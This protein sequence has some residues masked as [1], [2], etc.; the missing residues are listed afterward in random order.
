MEIDYTKLKTPIEFFYQWEKRTPNAVFLRQPSGPDWKTLTY[1]EAGQEARKMAAALQATGLEQGSHVGI[2]SKNC[3]HWVLSDLAIMMAGFVSVPFYPSLT[4]GQLHEV[5]TKSNTRLLIAGKLEEWE[6]K[7]AGVPTGLPII[8]F[9]HYAGN[10]LIEEGQAWDDLVAQHE[11]LGDNVKPALEDTWTILFTSGTT[12]TPKG[13]VHPY[14]NP[15]ILSHYES[16]FHFM[17]VYKLDG[18]EFLSF[19]PLNHVAERI[20]VVLGCLLSGGTISFVESIDTFAQNLQDTQPTLFFAVPR[21]WHKFQLAILEKLPDRRLQRLL[22]WPVLGGFIRR[23]IKKGLGLSRAQVVLTGASI[24]PESLKQWYRGLGINLREVY[25]STETCGGFT[26]MPSDWHQPNTVGRPVKG[27]EARI[28]PETG[29]I[30]IQT[31]WMMSEYYQE[32]ALTGKVLADGWYSSGDKGVLDEDGFLKVIGRVKD[33]FKTAKGEFVTPNPIEEH[34]AQNDHVEQVCITG[35]GLPQ[36]VALINVSEIAKGIDKVELEDAFREELAR[37]N[38]Q[39]QRH[40]KVSTIVIT[41]DNWSQENDLL[42]PTLKVRRHAI[43]A[44]YESN[45]LEWHEQDG[46][47]IWE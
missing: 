22:K 47:V 15:A 33:A 1:A 32:P 24:T 8:H 5:L 16:Q 12:G 17:G 38:Q 39:L 43:N 3:Y 14:R 46:E 45:L 30:L 31:P 20:A 4:A 44:H 34:F 41:R 10:A 21:I 40:E 19:L 11:P 29:E 26:I 23:R 6:Q 7:K 27:T 42:T 37:I 18:A 35:L 2:I 28:D 36:P 13:A 9:P 25:G